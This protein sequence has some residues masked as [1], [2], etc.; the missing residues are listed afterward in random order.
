MKLYKYMS[1]ENF[2]SNYKVRFTPPSE[3]NDPR[4]CFPE[5]VIKE[6]CLTI[7]GAATRELIH[8]VEEPWGKLLLACSVLRDYW[9]LSLLRRRCARNYEGQASPGAALPV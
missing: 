6:P 4:E 5:I 1:N 2:L 3:L 7:T 8:P 9:S